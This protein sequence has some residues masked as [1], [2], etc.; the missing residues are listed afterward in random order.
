[1][2][3]ARKEVKLRKRHINLH[4]NH[5]SL[6][7]VAVVLLIVLGVFLIR[8]AMQ[9][10]KLNSQFKEVGLTS[11][12]I[13]KEIDDLRSKTLISETKFSNCEDLKNN[14]V[15][16]ISKEQNKTL[17]CEDE[18]KSLELKVQMIQTEYS[19]N[20]TRME[21]E[22][23]QKKIAVELEVEQIRRDMQ[24][25]KQDFNKTIINAA[26]NICCKQRVD[27]QNIDSYT[28]TNNKIV[29]TSGVGEKIN[30]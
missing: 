17:K 2:E 8:P 27:D 13:L 26:N 16:K 22:V 30:C 3:K 12:A 25:L 15:Q 9:G 19:S 5:L 21:Q 6:I 11:G 7:L 10:Y 23:E 20:M 18:K 14:Y 4:H 24:A 28:I 1:M 29:C